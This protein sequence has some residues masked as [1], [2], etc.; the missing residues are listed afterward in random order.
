MSL[1]CVVAQAGIASITGTYNNHAVLFEVTLTG[2]TSLNDGWQFQVF[3]DEDGNSSTGYAY[4]YDRIVRGVENIQAGWVFVRY[5]SGGGGPGGWGAAT[6]TSPEVRVTMVDSLHVEIEVPLHAGD[7]S[8]GSFRYRFESYRNGRLLDTVASRNTVPG[9]AV[10]CVTDDD[11]DDGDACTTHF[12][13]AGILCDAVVDYDTVTECCDPASGLILA[14]DDDNACTDDSCDSATGT[15][16]HRPTTLTTP[17]CNYNGFYDPCDID[18]GI[19]ADCN[20]NAVPDECEPDCN[21]NATADECDIQFGNSQDCNRNAVPD[22]C[23][24]TS[25]DCNDNGVWDGCDIGSHASADC[26][27]NTVPDECDIAAGTL[28]DNDGDGIPDDCVPFPPSAAPYPHGRP[29]NRYISFDPN[30]VDNAGTLLAFTVELTALTLGSCDDDDGAPCRL[31]ETGG[32]NEPGDDDCR[33]CSSTGMPCIDATTDCIPAGQTCD[34][35]GAACV[36]DQENSVGGEWWVGPESPRGNGVHL[37]VSRPFRRIDDG[38]DW[39]DVVHVGDCEIVPLATY[40]VRAV[41]TVS[42]IESEG[43]MVRT[44]LRPTVNVAWWA[45]TV[46]AQQM[47]CNG[48]LRQAACTTTAICGGAPCLAVWG[49][50]DGFAGFDDVLAV[51]SAFQHKPSLAQAH[52]TWVDLHGDDSGTPG[53]EQFDPPNFVA[54]FSDVQ[55]AVLG[56]QGRPYPYF[57]PARCP[58]VGAWP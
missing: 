15:V 27:R 2:S 57:D 37:L 33:R 39:P 20:A 42:D 14:I 48:D 29:K 22:D 6:S 8:D 26:D 13:H 36:N 43:L 41:D 52:F 1:P 44:I 19:S 24:N 47:R 32:P 54:N 35:T 10:T 25:P 56:F 7:I 55:Q 17:D 30:K 49:E 4:G 31:V 34:V 40:M 50:P 53:S 28:V 12:C 58:D 5:V 21:G 16:S 9:L 23:E 45:D 3:I 18:A 38:G 46:G 51:L 11:C